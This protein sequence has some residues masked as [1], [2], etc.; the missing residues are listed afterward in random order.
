[1]GCDKIQ[2]QIMEWLKANLKD[3]VQHS[4]QA[5]SDPVLGASIRMQQ[6]CARIWHSTQVL[7]TIAYILPI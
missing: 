1:M 2:E 7:L 4:Q 3:V 5:D 6:A